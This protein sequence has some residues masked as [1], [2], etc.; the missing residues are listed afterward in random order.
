MKQFTPATKGMNRDLFKFILM[1]LMVLDHI[2][3]F[4]SPYLAD[5]FHILTRVVAVGF[6]YLVVE[7]LF[8]TH[9]RKLYL[10]RLLGWGAF[11]ALG[12]YLLNLF[13]LRKQYQMSILGD[14]IFLTLFI[15]AVIVCLW[16]NHQEPKKK[17]LLKIA[18]ILLLIIGLIPIF[19]GSFVILPFM[20]ITQLTHKNIKKRNWY[21]IGLMTVLLIIELPMA[22]SIPNPTPLMI[23]DSI[24]M[25][26]SDIFFISIIPF[27]HFYSGKLGKY[28]HKLK[29]LFYFFYPAH[30]WLI[31]LISNFSG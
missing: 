24:A 7:G 11:M 18:S 29:Y 16:D 26:A 8:Y 1:I 2:D 10:T 17:Q 3:N 30:L 20:L 25:N 19:E 31:H 5:T 15:G 6:A 22:L 27:L 14:N 9:S 13:V 21:Y 12:N 23:F 4:I 28:D